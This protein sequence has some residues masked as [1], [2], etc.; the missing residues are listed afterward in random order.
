MIVAPAV[1]ATT[2]PRLPG[3]AGSH[4]SSWQR[5]QT[6]VDWERADRAR[7][8]VDV[9]P[10]LDLMQRLGN[11]H[12]RV[13]S[14]HVTGTKG[15]GSVCALVEAGLLRA[16]LRAG[17]YAS[18]HLEHMSERVSLL[19][20]PINES[21]LEHALGLALDARDDAINQGS[22]G[23]EASWFDILTAAALWLFA[24]AGMEWAVIE[25]GL[26]GRL[27][28]TNVVLSELSV[29][30]N[31]GLEHTDVLGDTVQKIAAEKAGIIKP[32]RPVLTTV[33][34]DDPAGAVL[35]ETAR[36]QGADLIWVDTRANTGFTAANVLLARA[37]LDRLGQD[38]VMSPA[39][40]QPLGS[41]DLPEA[42]V[43]SARLPGRLEL[44][45]V[46]KPRSV[47][48]LQP[49]SATRVVLDGAHVGFALTALV[50]ELRHD[51]AHAGPAVVLLAIGADKNARDIMARLGGVASLVVCTRL[52]DGRSSWPA[53]ELARI[54]R[55]LGLQ[56]E[57]ADTPMQGLERCLDQ[58]EA[59]AWVLVTGSLYLVGE[60][61]P[62]LRRLARG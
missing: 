9:G 39:R 35:R 7:M 16:G 56:T 23:R 26:G 6:L 44:L 32:G 47:L 57:C 42:A 19:G 48:A 25:V 14:V 27:D 53:A 3:A 62:G 13:K 10:E 36:Q 40:N 50:E 33:A 4:I 15:K 21:D 29:I 30:C 37:V 51:P 20:Q 22:P 17:R 18:P 38:G 12:R 43:T 52:A 58:P 60:V 59:G 31:V 24:D 55:E 1:G 8:R 28:S 34:A 5:L 45:D 41:A 61:G 11:P 54:G 49:P 2:G 46:L